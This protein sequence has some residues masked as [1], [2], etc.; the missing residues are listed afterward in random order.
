M[1]NSGGISPLSYMMHTRAERKVLPK[2]SPHAAQQLALRALNSMADLK[3]TGLCLVRFLP[4]VAGKK[5]TS[6][7]DRV[8]SLT[9]LV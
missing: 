9:D 7:I 3:R 8:S 1:Y 6:Y 4:P 5:R 2:G